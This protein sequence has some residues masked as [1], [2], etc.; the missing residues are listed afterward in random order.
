MG[1]EAQG[2]YVQRF[3]LNFL[4]EFRDDD[5]AA[6]D[7]LPSSQGEPTYVRALRELKEADRT[8][9]FVDFNHLVQC[10]PHRWPPAQQL[11]WRAA[12]RGD[13][14]RCGA[15]S[16][17]D[18]NTHDTPP[19]FEDVFAHE[20][21]CAQYYRFETFLRKAV[22]V[23]AGCGACGAACF[24]RSL[25]PGDIFPASRR[26]SSERPRVCLAPPSRTS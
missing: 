26:A 22:Q 3:F 20:Y 18:A 4:E 8:T 21:V 12:A 1:T 24:V 13:R 23:R 9:L 15:P 16:L 17:T 5:T 19:R 2:A 14:R 10:V 6:A 11:A 7:G 25:S